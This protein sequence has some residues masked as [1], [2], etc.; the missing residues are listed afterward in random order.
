MTKVRAIFLCF[1]LTGPELGLACI[2]PFD[3]SLS[4]AKGDTDGELIL[5]E[6]IHDKGT[7]P[8]LKQFYDDDGFLSARITINYLQQKVGSDKVVHRENYKDQLRFLTARARFMRKYIRENLD[9]KHSEKLDDKLFTDFIE[10][11]QREGVTTKQLND[12]YQRIVDKMKENGMFPRGKTR[13]NPDDDWGAYKRHDAMPLPGG[14]SYAR[15]INPASLTGFNTETG[16][17]S[18]P[19]PAGKNLAGGAQ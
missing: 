9:S 18:S 12:G 5:T 3:S 16:F 14:V 4:V 17:K 13:T 11:T 10:L 6:T 7:K 2:N 8:N 19:R 15:C 1:L